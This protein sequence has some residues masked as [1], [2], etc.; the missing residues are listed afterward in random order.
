MAALRT[1]ILI[2][3]L[4]GMAALVYEILWMRIFTPVF[5]LSI[6]ATTAV[7]CAFMGGLG[8]GSV[9]APRFI[10][11]FGT[12]IWLLYAALEAGIG[13]GSLLVPLSVGPITAAYVATA[14]LDA[15]GFATGV[16]RFGLA[17]GVMLV[18]TFFM[19]LT[20]P[21]LVHAFRTLVPEDPISSQRVGTLYGINTVGAASGC[22]LV[23]FVLLFHLG[24]WRSILCTAALN[25][26]LAIVVVLLYGRRRA[27]VPLE[28]KQD[29]N[30]NGEGVNPYKP[31][32]ILLLYG[33]IGFT[34][35]GYELSWFRLL[36]F[37]LQSATDSFSTMLTVFLL[38]LGLGSLF[39]SRVLAPRLR[40]VQATTL[41][42]ILA[43]LQAILALLGVSAIPLYTK[44]HG[45]WRALINLY[46]AESWGIITLEKFLVASALILPPTFLM[47]IAFPLVAQLF[48]ARRRADSTTV[49]FLYGANTI[50][51]ILGSLCTGF[52]FFEW[53][54]VQYTLV[55]LAMMNLTV[56]MV[57]I[58]PVF[59]VGGRMR[60]G[61]AAVTLAVVIVSS[62]VSPRLLIERFSMYSGK[63]IYYS[64]SASDITYV[65]QRSD[66]HRQLHFNDGRGTSATLMEPNYINRLL[67][68]SSMAMN[69]DA[70]DILV[71][72]MGC[73]NTA[74]AFSKFNIDR[75]DIVDISGGAFE[76]AKYFF[77]NDGVLDD[78]RVH[79]YVEDGR[80][81]L[82]KSQ[83]KYDVIEIELPS[84]H[85]D[86]VVTLYTKEFYD[87]AMSR[88]NEGGVLSQWIDASQ[89]RR[90]LSYTLINTMRQTFP[91]S[92]VWSA[93]WA[94]WVN[95]VK[96][97]T[98][99]GVDFL[100]AK[101]LFDLPLVAE[102]AQGVESGFEDL[103]S[104]VVAADLILEEAVGQAVVATDDQTI[105]DFA[106]S[107]LKTT[108]ALG[109]G[110]AHMGSPMRSTFMNHWKQEGIDLT[111]NSM[112]PF[113]AQAHDAQVDAS[114]ELVARNFP[115]DVLGRIR[116][117]NARIE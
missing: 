78:P 4:S 21:V 89:A 91:G 59:R 92:V 2:A 100:P 83:R 16:V 7:L 61:F 24:I 48:K 63:I 70:K 71:I 65:V 45:L 95:G 82:L 51:A 10:R 38:G 28:P 87:I 66:G 76:A 36:V 13:I 35:F 73:G 117:N 43:F 96:G 102:D 47:G 30:S 25:F 111:E 60:W 109:G 1:P 3:F 79:T 44:L 5:G 114:L 34:S 23:G 41:G 75:L 11:R 94:W 72:S 84:I 99:P 80:N 17:F 42:G 62:Q 31:G 39:F 88:L 115:E 12:S 116:L 26:T 15:S 37:Y 93:K 106:I 108:H 97:E 110:V 103:M 54:G 85:A 98:N 81:Y 55:L 9:A 77:T 27:L 20:L 56:G 58:I 22:V 8:L 53:L 29:D 67:A 101:A 52:L 40:D 113:Y 32:L 105:V 64:E 74:A 86:G 112:P 6:H 68:Y 33:V 19:G 18:P 49:G 104:R 57:L 107:R 14:G 69:P 90:D 50:G 46:G